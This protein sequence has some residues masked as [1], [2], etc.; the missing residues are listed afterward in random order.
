MTHR[1]LKNMKKD[2][3]NC[4]YCVRNNTGNVTIEILLTSYNNHMNQTI[5]LTRLR[6]ILCI[7]EVLN[8]VIVFLIYWGPAIIN[9][10][11]MIGG[12]SLVAGFFIEGLLS[13]VLIE[14]IVVLISL[15]IVI[16]ASQTIV[17]I[18]GDNRIKNYKENEKY[19]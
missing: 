18:I 19:D 13:I 11:L 4:Y 1:V 12:V 16:Q 9:A 17:N 8:I 15:I 6:A 3:H 7:F 14:S 10:M 5:E 2:T